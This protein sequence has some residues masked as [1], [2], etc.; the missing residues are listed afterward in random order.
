MEPVKRRTLLAGALLAAGG[1]TL[2]RPRRAR[3]ARQQLSFV[4]SRP[5]AE[6]RT[7][8]LISLYTEA[9]DQMGLDFRFVEV[10]PNRAVAMD[11][12]G[13]ADGDLGRV[14][15]FGR[16]YPEMVRIDE[17]NNTVRFS[18]FS[19]DAAMDVTGW[20]WLRSY[21]GRVAARRGISEIEA[22]LEQYGVSGRI[23]RV[24]SPQQ[25]LMLL[26][27]G[28]ASLYLDE[29]DAVYD[30][31]STDGAYDALE[32]GPKIHE[33]G[34]MEITTGHAYLYRAR[35]EALAAPLS[36]TLRQLKAA[37]RSKRL[38]EDAFARAGYRPTPVFGA[39][40]V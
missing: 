39:R 9:L 8:W 21:D 28:R 7:Q 25:G 33:A 13:Q 12:S 17:P 38:L 24:E 36:A 30:Y 1:F 10:P 32:H 40:P 29:A 37:G 35:H 18:A 26:Q 11:R 3:A 19:A 22:R 6:P 14:Y 31:M 4:S 15:A 27:A 16:L 34:L 20:Q 2:A 5:E 23:D